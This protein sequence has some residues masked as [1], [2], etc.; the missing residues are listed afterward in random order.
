MFS[1]NTLTNKSFGG[2]GDKFLKLASNTLKG[3]KQASEQ[4]GAMTQAKSTLNLAKE[5]KMVMFITYYQT[6]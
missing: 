3:A 5:F 2:F 6:L 4:L 1:K